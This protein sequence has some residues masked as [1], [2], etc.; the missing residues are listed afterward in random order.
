MSGRVDKG[1]RIGVPARPKAKK[2]PTIVIVDDELDLL[3]ALSTHFRAAIP[4]ARIFPAESG[5]AALEFI[6]LNPPD[7]VIMDWRMPGLTGLEL[8][9]I[10]KLSRRPPA[11]ILMTAHPSRGLAHQATAEHG[12][13]A[14]FS[15]PFDP[16][17]M[18]STAL[19][20]IANRDPQPAPEGGTRPPSGSSPRRHYETLRKRAFD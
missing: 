6:R 16:A 15:K 4:K 17:V 18:V 10:L 3:M 11:T 7:L 1:R 2:G 13:S 14:I 12:F 5:P 19:G 9:G 20:L 8:A